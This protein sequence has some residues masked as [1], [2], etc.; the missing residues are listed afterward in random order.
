MTDEV[1][2]YEH[3]SNDEHSALEEAQRLGLHVVPDVEI[4]LPSPKHPIAVSRALVR[5]RYS[6]SSA[7]P[8]L[9]AWRGGF[10]RWEKSHWVEVPDAA[11]RSDAY[12]FTE[13]AVFFD[14]N[15]KK[16]A[17]APNR[18]RI[19]D[20]LDAL[21]A[22]THLHAHLQPPVW[23]G[24]TDAPPASE[25]VACANGLLHVPT[26]QLLEHDPRL[27]N[28]VAVPFDFDPGAPAPELWLRFL[29]DL[30]P[31]DADAIAALQEFFGY[32]VSGSTSLHKIML[33]VG[34]LR[35]G[36]GTIARVLTALVGRA[37]VT[38]PTLASLGQ[39]F[40]LQDLIGKSLA[41]VAD[42]RLGSG[43]S[44]VVERLLSI[45][46]EDTLTID[47]K[48]KDPWTG[49]LGTR[50]LIISNELPSFGDAS[51]A[52]AS[53]FVVLTLKRSWLGKENHALTSELLTEL[54]GIL[55]WAL[56]G[57]SRLQEQDRF[58]EPQSSID[59]TIALQDLVS[60]ISAFIRDRC[61]VGAEHEIPVDE[62]YRSWRSW[63]EDE[64]RDRPGSVAT[65]GKN[66]RAKVAGVMKI[67]AGGDDSREYR[68]VGI[69]LKQ[70]WPRPRTYPDA[71]VRV[72]AGVLGENEEKCRSDDDVPA[73]PSSSPL[74]SQ[75]DSSD[76]TP[77]ELFGQPLVPCA[78][79]GELTN[80][81]YRGCP[82]H[83]NCQLQEQ[84]GI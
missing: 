41:V 76:V 31:D 81:R 60:P 68:Y 14:D 72:R 73:R 6:H 84:G 26:R 67:R 17:W 28:T 39:N 37:N 11:V 22:I 49:Q 34:L 74:L 66:L 55:N 20:L 12:S 51:G 30:W 33:L 57:L 46:G 61:D 13:H 40:G 53:R 71:D 69:R 78:M 44:V 23:T 43:T 2:P 16:T 58:T 32:V 1:D 42:A 65:F 63:C 75:L 29:D 80:R 52:I 50:F 59:A 3:M 64:G 10:W 36:K 4:I 19:A 62:L 82:L 47:R 18:Y 79:C 9:R 83:V 35:S 54:P 15:R 7:D 27:F 48:Y 25:L 38:G 45:S 5:D 56:E 24:P 8:L 77:E 70:Q 21:R